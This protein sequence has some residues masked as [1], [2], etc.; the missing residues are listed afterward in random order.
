MTIPLRDQVGYLAF[1]FDD[2]HPWPRCRGDYLDLADA[3][4]DLLTDG[5][6]NRAEVRAILAATP[7]AAALAG[8]G[9]RAT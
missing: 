9:A 5:A 6:D 1:R 7:A 3:I 4:L 8:V 2:T